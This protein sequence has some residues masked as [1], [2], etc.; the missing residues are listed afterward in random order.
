MNALTEN[1]VHVENLV[2]VQEVADAGIHNVLEY[3]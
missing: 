1:R 3:F 2:I